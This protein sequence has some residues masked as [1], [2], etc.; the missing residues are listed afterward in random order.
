MK[1][2]STSILLSA[3]IGVAMTANTLADTWANLQ[4]VGNYL[5]AESYPWE[6]CTSFDSVDSSCSNWK[7]YEG[8]ILG[9]QSNSDDTSHSCVTSFS[10]FTGEIDK[11]PNYLVTIAATPDGSFKN[12]FGDAWYQQPQSY[13]RLIKKVNDISLLFLSVS[14][15]C[16]FNNI[17]ISLGRTLNSFSGVFNTAV[18][19][20]VYFLSWDADLQT[21]VD[22]VTNDDPTAVGKIIGYIFQKIFNAAVPEVTYGDY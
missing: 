13:I 11:V 14:N 6:A 1:S 20:F 15:N 21:M 18:T 2:I 9:L 4:T 17:L 3:F 19:G 16:S 5:L 10:S 7:I 22:G 12:I 8:V